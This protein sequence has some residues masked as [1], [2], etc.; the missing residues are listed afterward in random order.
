MRN[1]TEMIRPIRLAAMLA[2]AVLLSS[3]VNLGGGKVPASLM[4]LSPDAT[5]AAGTTIT[6]DPA[7]ALAVVEPEAAAKL[8]SNR[9]PVQ[10][11]AT[12]I[13]YLKDA[14]WVDAPVKLF[15]HLLG[16]TIRAKTGKLVVDN[17]DAALTPKRQLRGTLSEF[18]YD[19]QSMQAV[20]TYDAVLD[21]N[22]K[23]VKTRRFS[24]EVPV[25]KA[26]AGPVGAALNEAANKV[27][28]DVAEWVG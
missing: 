10:V 14:L 27:A 28:T 25:S 12:N 20:V 3:C 16:E 26:E 1:P 7:G 11:D 15:R 24:A 22:G 2:P 6:G 23:S 18:G 5:M 13:A 17:D 19:A 21:I 8:A 9:V 4:T